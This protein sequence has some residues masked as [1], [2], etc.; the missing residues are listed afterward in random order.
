[1]APPEG[2]QAG[3]SSASVNAASTKRFDAAARL[4]GRAAAEIGAERS[5]EAPLEPLLLARLDRLPRLFV[6]GRCNACRAAPVVERG[7]DDRPAEL[8]A[9]DLDRVADAYSLCRLGALAVDVDVP[10]DHGLAG[11]AA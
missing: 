3:A 10:A 1:M 8:A 2:A 6:K 7:D 4:F 5:R 9:L 11:R